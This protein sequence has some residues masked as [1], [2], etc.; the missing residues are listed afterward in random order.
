MKNT[1]T[2]ALLL[3]VLAF[4][5]CKKNDFPA[6]G[7]K[8]LDLEFYALTEDNSIVKID[9]RKKGEAGSGTPI[10]GLQSGEKI[11][12]IDFRPATG[13]LYGLGSSSRLYV[14]NQSTGKAVAVSTDPFTPAL[15]SSVVGFD[16]NPTVDRIRVVTAGGQNLRLNPETGGV[17]GIDG[18]LNPG[19]P[20]V[21]AVAYANS[22]AGASSTTL[23]DIDPIAGKLFKQ[24][25]P[26]NG[27][28]V[29]VGSLK[30]TV[31]GEG[32][33]DIS[34]DNKFAIAA[35][36]KGDKETSKYYIYTVDLN[37][38]KL[39][40][41]FE[42]KKKVT[43]L[44][45]PTQPVAY[46]ADL[47]G[48]LLI[49]NPEKPGTVVT[50]PFTGLQSGETVVGLDFR[51]A[52]AQLFALTSANRVYAVN[53]SSAAASAIGST[54]FAAPVAGVSY[55]FDFNPTVDRIRLVGSNGVNLRLNPITG[56]V[57]A[58][59]MNLNPGSPAV[60][61]A[62]YTNSFAGSTTTVLYDIDHQA[63]KL[64]KQDPP[65]NGTL[66]EVGSLGLS[67]DASNGFDI[68]GMSN[69]AWGI[70]TVGGTSSIYSIDL[71]TGKATA[72]GNF[73]SRVAGFTVGLGF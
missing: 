4:V 22:V 29:E 15:N 52:T 2:G 73:P 43:G 58:T 60:S 42:L 49:F 47:S 70:F 33:F 72:A 19:T 13:Q 63:G 65:N 24:D 8:S 38:G 51:P 18:N 39:D 71:N 54:A 46:A 34:P 50:K 57:A 67:V 69:K 48:N 16:F 40:Y 37:S 5:S 68:G 11:V 61:A 21:T 45:I 27:T 20:G 36:T 12:A 3:F 25:P 55:G 23:Y 31:S 28:L 64:F 30:E 9:G 62:A 53:T 59:D 6:H 17:A 26:N 10:T 41:A 66:V 1:I 14:I 44:A 35:F 32:G 7:G 56:A